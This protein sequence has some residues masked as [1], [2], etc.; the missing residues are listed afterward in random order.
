[1]IEPEIA[2]ADLSDNARLPEGF[3]T[4]TFETLLNERQENLA[5]FDEPIR[6]LGDLS[7]GL[8]KPSAVHGEYRCA[9]LKIATKSSPGFS[10]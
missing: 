6:A 8:A 10:R 9:V 1:M 2:F 4:Y 3:L 7:L 5:F